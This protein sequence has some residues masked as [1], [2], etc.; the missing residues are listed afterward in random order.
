ML[1]G[2]FAVDKDFQK[3]G[4]AASLLLF[5]PKSTLRASEIVD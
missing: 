3:Q 4:H 1:L 2:R 5:A